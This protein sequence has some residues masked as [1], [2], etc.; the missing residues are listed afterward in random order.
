VLRWQLAAL[1]AHAV[2][3]TA[4]DDDT[5]IDAFR[6]HAGDGY[7][8]VVDYLWGRP[9]E[10]LTRALVP[11]SFAMPKPTRVVHIGEAAGAT[12]KLSG[13]A[14]RT[15]G[16]EIYGAS[17]NMATGMAAAYQQV[18]EWVRGGELAMNVTTTR[19]SRIEDAWQRTDL[20]GSRL[21]ILPD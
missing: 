7:D 19:L 15:S 8:V 4:A 20:R 13:D 9:T 6:S 21:V 18:V 1:G 5:L 17:R 3:N 2:I 14:I 10:L 11:D 16:L 12:I